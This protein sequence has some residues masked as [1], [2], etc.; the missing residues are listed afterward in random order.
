M[1]DGAFVDLPR[2]L[3]LSVLDVSKAEVDIESLPQVDYLTL[4]TSQWHR[5]SMTPAAATLAGE[6][7]LV[8]ALARRVPWGYG[9]ASRPNLAATSAT[10]SRQRDGMSSGSMRSR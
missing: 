9:A 8:G 4:N 3:N 6:S 10:S 2:L 1:V 7:S 5:C